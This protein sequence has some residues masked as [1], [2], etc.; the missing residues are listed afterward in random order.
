MMNIKAPNIL[1]DEKILFIII[2]KNKKLKEMNA[3]I[4]D[5]YNTLPQGYRNEII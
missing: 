2:Y 5:K 1:R 4:I 3:L